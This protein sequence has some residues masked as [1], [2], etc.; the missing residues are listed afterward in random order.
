MINVIKIKNKSSKKDIVSLL[1][2]P[3]LTLLMIVKALVNIIEFEYQNH[4]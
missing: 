3:Q 1:E 4:T 2:L